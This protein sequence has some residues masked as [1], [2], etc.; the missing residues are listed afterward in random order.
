MT[1]EEIIE[2]LKNRVEYN[3]QHK[4]LAAARGDFQSV[5]QF[6]NEIDNTNATLDI[7]VRIKAE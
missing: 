6:Q 1:I 4:N 3:T 7:L 5:Q 2:F